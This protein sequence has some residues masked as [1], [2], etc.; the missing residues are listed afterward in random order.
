MLIGG[1]WLEDLAAQQFLV[2]VERHGH[3]AFFVGGCVRNA[4]MQRPV[5]DIDIATSASPEMVS[6]IAE[7]IGFRVIPTGLSHGTVTILAHQTALEVTTF[8]R[9]LVTDGRHAKVG[10]TKSIE[11]DAQRRDFTMN[12]IYADRSGKVI[13][14]I[15]GLD[16]A[17]NRRIRFVGDPNLRIRED[18]LRILRFFRFYAVYG[19]P[20]AGINAEG[21]AACTANLAGLEMLSKERIG[22]EMRKLLGAVCPVQ[23]V[24]SMAQAGVLTCVLPGADPRWLGLLHHLEEGTAL[25]WLR[26]LVAIG[27]V[28]PDQNL[29]LSRD[30]SRIR[31][32]LLDEIGSP[33]SPAALGWLIGESKALDVMLLRSAMFGTTLPHQWKEEVARGAAAE[34]P[35]AARD[36]MPDLVGKAL[37]ARLRKI[38]TRWLASDLQLGK[39][40]LLA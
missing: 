17:V 1:S 15:G 3:V 23:A 20:E 33:H 6:N 4:L 21:L 8:R 39:A 2:A 26:R 11:E 19:D 5:H 9:D 30:E 13:D 18:Y 10:Y 37:G 16:D 40:Q 24:A 12:A 25:N 14:P 32:C 31:K 36:L 22:S 27:G 28:N 29:R 38:E 7:S 35:V 34:L